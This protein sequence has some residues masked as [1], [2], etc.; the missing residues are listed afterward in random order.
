MKPQRV[1]VIKHGALGDVVFALSAMRAIREH[2]P[3]A[4][5][6][7]QTTKPFA[8]FLGASA[9]ADAI[10]PDGRGGGFA[11]DL[12]RIARM[13]AA[14]FDVVYDLQRSDRAAILRWFV[15]PLS[16]TRWNGMRVGDAKRL[17]AANEKPGAT[18]IVE[19]LAQEVARAG[20]PVELARRPPDVSWAV[21]R[22]KPPGAFGIEGPFLLFAAA[23]S[24]HR[25]EKRW[26][27]ARFAEAARIAAE[28]GVAPV[29]LGVAD[30]RAGLEA[31]V[32]GIASGKNLAG[33]TSLFDIASLGA[34]AKGVVGNDTGP[35]ILAA[36][37]GAPAVSIYSRHS[38]H[39]DACAPLSA[40]GVMPLRRSAIEEIGVDDVVGAL[41]RLG[42]LPRK[43]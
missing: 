36:A 40:G 17:K 24:A 41:E 32:V 31:I 11:A 12:G 35:A 15:Q 7:L 34:A 25:D 22:G 23:A 18:H 9:Y 21:A 29:L 38:P 16:R 1:L 8:A 30:E 39:P 3:Q 5:I 6:T 37:A 20:V 33:Q 27:P 43:A 13:R 42:A 19:A 26:P 28:R 2:H 10:D 14:R 4:H